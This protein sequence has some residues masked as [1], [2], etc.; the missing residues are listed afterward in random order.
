MNLQ[1]HC[2]SHSP[3]TD[4]HSKRRPRATNQ[5]MALPTNHESVGGPVHRPRSSGPA[6]SVSRPVSRWAGEASE[7]AAENDSSMPHHRDESR[8]SPRTHSVLDPEVHEV[9]R[10]GKGR[11]KSEPPLIWLLAQ[12]FLGNTDLPALRTWEWAA[13]RGP[14]SEI[15]SA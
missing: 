9:E 12:N 6:P 11:S 2:S 15:R 1:H 4:A 3:F 5:G 14:A 13:R 7:L 10:G 8:S